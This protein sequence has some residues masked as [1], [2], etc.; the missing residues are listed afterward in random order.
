MNKLKIILEPVVHEDVWLPE[1]GGRHPDV[2][3]VVVLRGVPPHVRVRPLLEDGQAII[4]ITK[5]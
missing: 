3:H 4:G 1:V 2:L 5:Y